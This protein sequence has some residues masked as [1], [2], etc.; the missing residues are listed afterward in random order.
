MWRAEI[1]YGGEKKWLGHWN[2]TEKALCAYDLHDVQ[3]FM[4]MVL[5]NLPADRG[6][7]DVLA[8]SNI[9]VKVAVEKEHHQTKLLFFDPLVRHF[10]E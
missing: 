7:V 6:R 3:L 1:G 10:T 9:I 8:P 2:T 5:L 4:E